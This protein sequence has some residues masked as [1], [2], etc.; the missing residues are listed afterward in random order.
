MSDPVKQFGWDVWFFRTF[1]Y[2]MPCLITASFT[3]IGLVTGYLYLNETLVQKKFSPSDKMTSLDLD[4]I[5][6]GALEGDEFTWRN[7]GSKCT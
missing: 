2:L 6:L 7:Y 5:E 4:S 1:P 3:S